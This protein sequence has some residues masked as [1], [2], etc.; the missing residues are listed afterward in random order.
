M[1]VLSL[2]VVMLKDDVGLGAVAERLHVL[3]S[4]LDEV[5]IGELLF[6]MGI[7]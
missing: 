7:E 6:G 3:L 2:D 5:L 4:Y 1:D